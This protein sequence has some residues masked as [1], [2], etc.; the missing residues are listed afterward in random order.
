[1]TLFDECIDALGSKC[2][3]LDIKITNEKFIKLGNDFPMCKWGG[4]DWEKSNVI[5]KGNYSQEV[6]DSLLSEDTAQ[7]GIIVLW[8]N[9]E[10]PAITTDLATVIENIYDV[11]AV[12]F[13]TWIFYEKEGKVIEFH[14][15][16]GITLGTCAK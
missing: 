8:D 7:S 6:F 9:A 10:I 11:L 12:S 1:M 3:V 14:H 5:L 13:D 4:I 15:D 16:K 2:E